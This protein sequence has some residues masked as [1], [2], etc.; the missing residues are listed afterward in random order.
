MGKKKK[1]IG[2]TTAGVA[3]AAITGFTAQAFGYSLY[4]TSSAINYAVVY[5]E[6]GSLNMGGPGNYAD[7]LKVKNQGQYPA[8]YDANMY[9]AIEQGSVP[10]GQGSWPI[11][12][13][14][15]IG[16][17]ANDG[18][19]LVET[20]SQTNSNFEQ[21]V[22]R[23]NGRLSYVE[24]YMTQHNETISLYDTG[25]G[26]NYNF[27]PLSLLA[28]ES[29]AIPTTTSPQ[30]TG[31]YYT[32]PTSG[33]KCPIY[34]TTFNFATS[35]WPVAQSITV[36]DESNSTNGTV[37]KGD[38]IGRTLGSEVYMY[39]QIATWHFDSVEFTNTSTGATTWVLGSGGNDK[40]QM[41]NF[42]GTESTFS[43]SWSGSGTND[44]KLNINTSNMTPGTYTATFYVGDEADRISPTA[45]TSFTIAPGNGSSG[46]GGNGGGHKCPPASTPSKPSDYVLSYNWYPNG[47]GGQILTWQDTN[48]V[49]QSSTNSNGCGVYQWRDQPVTYSHNYPLNLSNLQVTGLFYDPGKPGDLWSPFNTH[50]SQ[51]N[52]DQYFDGSTSAG[53]QALPTY[54]N[55]NGSPMIYTRV[56]GGFSFRMMWTGA[57][58]DMPSNA[59]VSYN[60]SNPDGEARTWIKAYQLLPQTIFNVGDVPVWDPYGDGYPPPATEYGWAYTSIPKYASPSTPTGYNELTAWNLTG[61]A[62]G[63]AH[64][65]AKVTF[66][67]TSGAAV[68]WWNSSQY[69]AQMLNYPTWFFI[70]E[71]S[72][73][74]S[75]YEV[76]Q[77]TYSKNYTYSFPQLGQNGNLIPTYTAPTP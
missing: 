29:G 36:T 38:T 51:S 66:T 32:D 15:V 52:N 64:I 45:T 63:A 31:S 30:P 7:Q 24:S 54:G 75:P 34:V 25:T 28:S 57:P 33:A 11:I 41:V 59:S 19:L 55:P 44:S 40:S 35:K 14:N 9:A 46:G 53:N 69:M 26:Q 23:F 72:V 39:K 2:V 8:L 18:Y 4:P 50:T 67:T 71:T 13:G 47:S 62:S 77:S 74:N 12:Q 1:W 58:N 73:P 48:W 17:Q 21:W 68:S 10:D 16:T 56:G 65:T 20:P 60:L 43:D 76:N 3:V 22:K 27:D 37:V 61:D 49:L 42:N 70:H 5:S 6:Y